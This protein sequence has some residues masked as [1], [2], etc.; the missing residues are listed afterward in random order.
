M[1]SWH[2]IYPE[3]I[4]LCFQVQCVSSFCPGLLLLRSA[5]VIKCAS[6]LSWVLQVLSS[7]SVKQHGGTFAAWGL[8]SIITEMV[9]LRNMAITLYAFTCEA[10]PYN[11]T[12]QSCREQFSRCW[13]STVRGNRLYDSMDYPLLFSSFLFGRVQEDMPRCSKSLGYWHEDPL[14]I[15]DH[16]VEPPVQQNFIRT[17]VHTCLLFPLEFLV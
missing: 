8:N 3:Y 7:G 17:L 13:S 11:P 5:W 4:F 6:P 12:A 2:A 9:V 10:Q 15:K 16:R 14:W 1:S